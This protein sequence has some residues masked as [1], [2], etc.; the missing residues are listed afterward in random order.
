M[1]AHSSP[2]RSR[3]SMSP[4]SPTAPDQLGRKMRRSMSRMSITSTQT[5]GAMKST[6]QR[7]Q[8][9]TG[10]IDP[11]QQM[12]CASQKTATVRIRLRR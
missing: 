7:G 1:A 3:L 11:S 8:I 12:L 2:I 5:K 6:I 9:R 10:R 4:N